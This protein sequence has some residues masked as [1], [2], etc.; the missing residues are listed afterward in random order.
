MYSMGTDREDQIWGLC[1]GRKQRT[2]RTP[3]Y[4]GVGGLRTGERVRGWGMETW[5]S[6]SPS[7]E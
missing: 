1:E 6:A 3:V 4:V 2:S 5:D 7:S